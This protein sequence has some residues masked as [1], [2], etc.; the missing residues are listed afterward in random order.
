MES[1]MKVGIVPV[2]IGVTS[3]QA[4]LGVAMAAEAAGLESVWTFEH[5]I[6]PNDYDSK[7]PYHSSGKMGVAPET[8]F[9]DPLITLA[10]IAAATRTLRLGTG[11]NI[12]PQSNPLL[13]A[14]QAATLDA[15]SGGRFEL[16]L[17]IGW[18]REE[19]D[20]MGTPFARRGARF[21]DYLV[22]MKK[23]W[24][25]ETVEHDGEFVQWRDFKSYPR[26]QQRPHMPIV[27]GGTSDRAFRRVAE[28]ADAWFAPNRDVAEL[29][30][31][32]GRLHTICR[33]V[34]RDPE[35]VRVTAMW[36]LVKER[37]ALT[38][39]EDL[40]VDRLVVPLHAVGEANPFKAIEVIAS[41]V[42]C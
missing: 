29:K 7:Y 33:D 13:L 28:H 36:P 21:D 30:T 27:I 25:G 39:Y 24:T 32:L 14:K 41:A 9:L 2:N 37:G 17:G 11:I 35:T 1:E 15:L 16:G 19:F 8:P 42:S 4:V 38:A 20:A 18:L 3:S 12:L 26:P 23:V 6:V 22:A 10:H 31:Q 5:V 40:G 34:G